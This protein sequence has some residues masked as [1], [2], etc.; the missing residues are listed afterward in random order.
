[1]VGS[2]IDTPRGRLEGR[3]A[4]I[5]GASRGI[6]E[7]I[8]LE[9]ARQ[10]CRVGLIATGR[11]ALQGVSSRIETEGGTALVLPLDVTDRDACFAAVAEAER[12]FGKVDILVNAAGAHIANRFIDYSPDDFQR[13][14]Q[15]NL[16]GPLHFMQAVLPGMQGRRYGKIVNIASTAGKWASAN[17]SAYNTSK[18]ALVGLTRCV[19]LEAGAFGI[20][21]NAICPGF[22]DTKMMDDSLRAVAALNN[23]SFED[24]KAAGMSRV[25]LKRAVTPK[26]VTDL[27]LYL[28]SDEAASMTGQSIVLDGGMLFI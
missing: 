11:D 4:L 25:V 26:E 12:A 9:Y 28:A 27:A 23:V 7:A 24:M 18:H 16:F 17:Q 6:G 20:N 5:T 8:A 22:V 13:L 21:V 14:L 10:G 2:K 19:A 3:A 15:V 1:M